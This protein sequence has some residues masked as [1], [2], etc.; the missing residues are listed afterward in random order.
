MRAHLAALLAAVTLV[1]TSPDVCAQNSKA[2]RE[3]RKLYLEG[4]KAY[5]EA[6]YEA[7]LD[8]FQRAYELSS[9]PAL[10]Y[11]IGNA[12]ERLGRHREAA[13]TLREYLPHAKRSE[14]A[15]IEKR[16]EN[17]EKR[18]AEEEKA[19]AK[20]EPEPDPEP[21]PAPRPEPAPAEPPPEPERPAPVLG[22]VLV[23]V[24][25]AAILGGAIAGGLALGARSD[26]DAGCNE[27]GGKRLCTAEASDAIDRDRTLSLI[28]DVSFGVGLIAAGVGVY[29]ILDSNGKEQPVTGLRAS[30]RAGGGEMTFVTTF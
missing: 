2:D 17:L 14:K 10:L 23:G 12:F 22:Y 9:R 28:A 13:D 19:A 11:N 24:G 26:A 8:A 18:A 16:I 6:R 1:A 20:P 3:A 7:A 29:L 21:K 30:P 27:S 25:G 15:T 4:D 5:A